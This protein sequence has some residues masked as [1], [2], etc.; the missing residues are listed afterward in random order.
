V[1]GDQEKMEVDLFMQGFLNALVMVLLVGGF[2]FWVGY[3][4]K[5]LRKAK[6]YW[7]KYKVLKRKHKEEDIALLMP[8]FEQNLNESELV[9]SL[10]ISGKI[11]KSKIN[12]LLYIYRE[13]QGGKT[14]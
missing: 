12:E 13:M 11:K 3:A 1:D 10:Y 6:K 5:K 7:F 2:L 14:K 9:K 4:L 8:F